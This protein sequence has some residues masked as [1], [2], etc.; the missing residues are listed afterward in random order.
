MST[1]SAIAGF[2]R[3]PDA[4]SVV[5]IR[6]QQIGAPTVRGTDISV[7]ELSMGG[8]TRIV[9]HLFDRSYSMAPVTDLMIRDFNE[10]YVEAIKEAREDDISAL[11]LG[12]LSFSTTITPIW[13]NGGV[14]FHPLDELPQLTLREYNPRRGTSTSLHQAIIDG[15]A[16][17]AEYGAQIKAST[18]SMPEID[19]NILADGANNEHPRDEAVVKQ[20]IDGARKDLIR[21]NF[22]FFETDMGLSKKEFQTWIK[23]LG[24]DMENVQNF[25]SQPGESEEE[26]KSR[27]R[28]MV[29]VMSRVSASR[30]TSAVNAAAATAAAPASATSGSSS[31]DEVIL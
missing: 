10:V 13:V 29:R 9:M 16:I 25:S 27:F 24:F 4:S 18:G 31:E 20:V 23:E 28:R 3:D 17:A 1:N 19:I 2:F 7:D 15:T 14:S 22:F 30:G 26:R 11:R 6:G 8:G 12:G 5:S 21:Y